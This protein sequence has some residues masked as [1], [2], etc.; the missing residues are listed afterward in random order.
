MKLFLVRRKLEGDMEIDYIDK[1]FSLQKTIII[2]IL[3]LI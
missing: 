2:I 1:I 3:H